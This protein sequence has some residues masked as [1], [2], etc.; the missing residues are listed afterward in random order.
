MTRSPGVRQP[1]HSDLIQTLVFRWEPAGA[2]YPAWPLYQIECGLTSGAIALLSKREI[3]QY[4]CQCAITESILRKD[5]LPTVGC[6]GA[7][8]PLSVT[9]D[10]SGVFDK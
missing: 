3:E 1:S 10:L 5:S 9:C 6:Q 8:S 7:F 4:R 2:S